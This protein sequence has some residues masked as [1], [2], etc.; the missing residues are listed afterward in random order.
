MRLIIATT[1]VILLAALT[2]PRARA[3]HRYDQTL[4][5]LAD[6]IEHTAD[7]LRDEVR[8]HYRHR[9]DYGRLHY[10]ASVIEDKARHI[11]H[12]VDHHG[13]P[14]HI[15]DDIAEIDRRTHEFRDIVRR[16]DHRA[17]H[18]GE[19]RNERLHVDEEL[20][21]LE[22]LVHEIGDALDDIVAV[23]S[24]PRPPVRVVPA[25]RPVVVDRGHPHRGLSI[26][27]RWGRVYFSF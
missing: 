10:V 19:S 21:Q 24:H 12:V 25:P 7:D 15:R 9:H 3:E 11:E 22:V 2:T 1:A 14:R 27:G 20:H 13:S 4:H 8:R 5:R 23:S 18:Y 6:A 16:S 17:R 26:G